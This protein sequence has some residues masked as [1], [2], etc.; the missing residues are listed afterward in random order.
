[1]ENETN[2]ERD[3]LLMTSDIVAAYVVKN[4][5]DADAVPGLIT[6]VAN[7]LSSVGE[8]VFE[9]TA[10]V[11]PMTAAQARKLVTSTGIV[12]MIDG[13]EFKSMKRHVGL[14]GYTPASY[15]ETFGLP[16]DFPMV[17]PAYA[18]MRSNLAKTMGLGAGGRS[19]AKAKPGRK[20]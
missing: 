19:G 16:S 20:P 1:M 9:E 7:A 12:S 17:H 13:R 15:R 6:T 18:Q 10:P 11:Q 5:I 14:H 4:K 2:T 3:L 8:P